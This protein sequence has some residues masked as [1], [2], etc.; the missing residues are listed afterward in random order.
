MSAITGVAPAD[1]NR[2]RATAILIMVRCIF[3]SLRL[4][5]LIGEQP[6]HAKEDSGFQ[7]RH[8]RNQLHAHRIGQRLAAVDPSTMLWQDCRD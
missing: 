8:R 5:G 6:I 7:E 4:N 3:F 1:T 2:S